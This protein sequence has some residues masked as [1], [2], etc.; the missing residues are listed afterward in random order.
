MDHAPG[1]V[2]PMQAPALA[3]IIKLLEADHHIGVDEVEDHHA[4]DVAV[5]VDEAIITDSDNDSTSKV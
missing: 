1:P 2:L 5:P 3:E 4:L